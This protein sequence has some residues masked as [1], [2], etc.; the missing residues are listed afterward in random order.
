MVEKDYGLALPVVIE[1]TTLGEND[2]IKITVKKR[3]DGDVIIEKD[4]SNIQDN[5]LG[6][7]LTEAES[8]LL[9]V[10]TYVYRLDWYQNGSFMCNIIP[11]GQFRVV[12]KA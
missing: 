4:Y 8:D 9:P 1:G 3:I 10:G 12:N 2:T 11:T 6:F 5:Q 7:V